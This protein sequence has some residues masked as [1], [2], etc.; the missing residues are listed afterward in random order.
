MSNP[1][2]LVDQVREVSPP[3]Q[4][5]SEGAGQSDHVIR[6]S[7]AEGRSGLLDLGIERSSVWAE[8]LESCREEGT[9]VYVEVDP[10]TGLIRE[11]LIPI[12]ATVESIAPVDDQD[13]DAV[14]LSIS[15]AR[16]VLRRD[17][18]DYEELSQALETALE[19]GTALLVTENDDHEIIHIQRAPN[20]EA[21]AV[22]EKAPDTIEAGSVVSLAKARNLFQIVNS[23][24]C[25]PVTAPVPCIPY[26]YPDDGCWGRA[27]EM[28][29]II[30]A[31]G[32]Q[33]E[34]VWIY[35]SLRVNTANNPNCK[36]YWGWHVA[37]TLSVKAGSNTVK[38]VID[39]SMFPEPVPQSKWA[40]AQGDPSPKLAPSSAAVYYRDYNGNVTYDSNYSKT[41]SV[42]ATYRNRLKIRSAGP[43]GPPP[44]AKCKP[45]TPL[46]RLYRYWNPRCCDHFYTT[47]WNEL[48]S[49]AHGWR[50]EGI[51]CY[52]FK[53]K[54]H[55]TVPLYR[56]WNPGGD[57]FYTTNWNELRNGAHGWRLEGI[58]CYVCPSRR[59]QT[60]PLFRYWNP[61]C[62]DHF[63][64]TNWN[65]L[66]N[67]A[68]GWRYEGIQCY[69]YRHPV[70]RF[71]A[72]DTE[73]VP[74]SFRVDSVVGVPEEMESAF[75]MSAADEAQLP[76]EAIE[77]D[78]YWEDAPEDLHVDENLIASSF[79]TEEA[80]TTV[81]R[82]QSLQKG[83][84]TIRIDVGTEDE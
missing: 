38:Y 20:S 77:L 66:R 12:P 24:T 9:S 55:G 74:S 48:R 70:T 81:E 15:S 80:F 8:V 19:A 30:I 34:K 61:R 29:R 79:Q 46:V 76:D 27:H 43:A 39:P 41:K 54:Q 3:E 25:P 18:P 50:Y 7:F 32:V 72:E 2:A 71:G 35:G 22:L 42:L 78:P 60:V 31:N 64:T 57:H 10:E 62:G 69:V 5:D 26:K 16:H 33:P 68:H 40:A 44:Y 11:L 56:Y 13:L 53:S 75:E 4:T 51:Q 67:G 1:N 14:Y 83:H 6:V 28:V 23:K 47:N 59:A 58:Q 21:I 63:Y 49:G 52:V 65:E 82:R 37:P 45:P 36:V 73:D 17:N 84:V